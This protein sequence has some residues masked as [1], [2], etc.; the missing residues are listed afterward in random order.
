MSPGTVPLASPVKMLQSVAVRG[1]IGMNRLVPP[2][3]PTAYTEFKNRIKEEF[4]V[5]QFEQCSNDQLLG[6]NISTI[7]CCIIILLLLVII[8]I[9]LLK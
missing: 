4:S 6:C 3:N 5:E 9:L 2:K 1:T 7:C 8:A